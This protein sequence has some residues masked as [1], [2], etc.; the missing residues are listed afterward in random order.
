MSPFRG[1][2]PIHVTGRSNPLLRVRGAVSLVQKD[3]G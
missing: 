2:L 1:L 3:L